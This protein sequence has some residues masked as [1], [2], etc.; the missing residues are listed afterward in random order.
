[1]SHNNVGGRSAPS[2]AAFKDCG[3]QTNPVSV[4]IPAANHDFACGNSCVTFVDVFTQTY[5]SAGEVASH[6]NESNEETHSASI[7]LDDE[8]EIVPYVLPKM[9]ENRAKE[10]NVTYKLWEN[11]FSQ[12]S[13]FNDGIIAD[14][15][16]LY[17]GPP[18]VLAKLMASR[19]KSLGTVIDP[20][21][22]S[23]AIAIQLAMVCR[24]VI[25]MDSDPVKIAF[26]R[27]NACI[28]GVEDR[29]IF[30]VGDFFENAHSLQKADGIVTSPPA[31]MTKDKMQ[32]LTDLASRVAPKVLLKLMK[33]QEVADLYQLE[34][35]KYYINTEKI[36]IDRE[37][38]S[39]LAFLG[40]GINTNNRNVERTQKKVLVFSDGVSVNRRVH[41]I[42]GNNLFA[43]DDYLKNVEEF[44]K[45][46]SLN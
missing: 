3:S 5:P 15:V 19:C 4:T 12:F 46:N 13:K 31:N 40:P 29:I 37:P 25:A 32:K 11:R 33:D 20:F 14:P 43:Y 34:N 42:R 18:E 22:G 35:I 36:C 16:T 44:V 9:E 38:N 8:D 45:N 30:L 1:M 27:N 10:L 7:H 17:S 41:W 6:V 28:Y 2:P 23:G 24:K 21:C 39:I 26:A